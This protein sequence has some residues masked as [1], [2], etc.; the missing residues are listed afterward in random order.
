MCFKCKGWKQF[1][2]LK[3]SLW[4]KWWLRFIKPVFGPY[5]GGPCSSLSQIAV[6]EVLLL[7]EWCYILKNAAVFRFPRMDARHIS[8][9]Y[10]QRYLPSA[11]LR[12]WVSRSNASDVCRQVIDWHP[13]RNVSHIHPACIYRLVSLKGRLL[14]KSYSDRLKTNQ[15]EGF[16]DAAWHFYAQ[17][18]SLRLTE[19]NGPLMVQS[20][21][22]TVLEVTPFFTRPT[23]VPSTAASIRLATSTRLGL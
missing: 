3:Y 10:Q 1:K 14:V 18:E 6:I 7:S 13:E 5:E 23:L 16:P 21:L 2:I 8:T 20:H 15:M 17:A 22:R 9:G 12:T 4:H 11:T 19:G